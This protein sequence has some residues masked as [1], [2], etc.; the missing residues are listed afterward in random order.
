[1]IITFKMEE[2]EEEEG[3]GEGEEGAFVMVGYMEEPVWRRVEDQLRNGIK[4]SV[5]VCVCDLVCV[6]V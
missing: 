4:V 2:E 3:E 5:C 1:M 6:C